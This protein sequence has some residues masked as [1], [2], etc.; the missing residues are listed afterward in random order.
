[1]SCCCQNIYRMC[2]VS[3]CAGFD[4]VL[5]IPIQIA[6]F[7]TLELDFNGMLHTDT[8]PFSEGDNATFST[9][10]LNEHFTYTGRL[11]NALGQTV[12]FEVA[13]VTYDCFQFTTKRVLNG[14]AAS[15]SI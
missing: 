10:D 3:V 4:F 2:E 13:G 15:V 7:Y 12:S 14:S 11:V 1:M 9:E 5:P 8:L 6:G